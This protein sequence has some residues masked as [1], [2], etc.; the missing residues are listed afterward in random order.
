MV[1]S[2]VARVLVAEVGVAT[3]VEGFSALVHMHFLH[4]RERILPSSLPIRVLLWRE[5][6]E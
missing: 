4:Q 5:H 3:V 1:G 2:A 6:A